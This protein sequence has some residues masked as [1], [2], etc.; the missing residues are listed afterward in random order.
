MDVFATGLLIGIGVASGMIGVTVGSS[1]LIAIPV[2]LMMGMESVPAIAVNKFAMISASFMAGWKYYRS[3]LL[4]INSFTLGLAGANLV[5][6]FIGTHL[7]LQ[8]DERLME[9]LV[10]GLLVAVFLVFI[11]VPSLG[12]KPKEKPLT[13]S[14]RIKSLIAFFILGL[15]M[16]FFGPGYGTLAIFVLVLLLGYTFIESSALMVL[17]GYPGL[18]V[19][20]GVFAWNDAIDYAFGIPL[21]IGV[22]VGGWLGAHLAVLK[23]NVWLRWGFIMITAVLIGNLMIR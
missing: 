13:N 1:A 5:G 20:V 7:V 6:A 15:Y 23:G 3:D 10:I 11:F 4:P 22:A 12:L 8:V 16:G 17:V 14:L 21:M 2:L 18:L 9:Y 19:S